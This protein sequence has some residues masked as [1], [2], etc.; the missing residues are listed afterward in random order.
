MTRLPV[1]KTH[2]LFIGGTFPRSESGRS[3]RVTSDAGT[4]HVCRASRK[5][6]R[7][8]VEAARGA[9]RSWADASASLRGQILYRLGEMMEGKGQELARA[10]LVGVDGADVAGATREVESAID[11]VI[12]YAGWCDKYAQIAG[13][14][15]P[16]AGAYHNFTVPEPVGVVGVVCPDECP[17]L[18]LVSLVAPAVCV[19]NTCVVLASEGNPI[20]ACVLCEAIGTSDLP[21]GVVNV[22]TGLRDELVPH[23]ASH[24]EINAIH[25]ANLEPGYEVTLRE[26]A[27]ENL[28][29]VT[30]RA[31]AD[32]FDPR[33]ES[34]GWIDPLVNLKTLWHPSAT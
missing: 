16:V 19:G 22:L 10:L 27:G 33:C 6:L 5:D 32:F 4:W 7:I 28:K 11:R 34:P 29:R 18:G 8:G 9:Q 13:C 23:F 3:V 1:T 24:R 17:L 2:K 20:P 30:L 31:H 15:N 26:G 21:R 25:G 14:A 12:Y